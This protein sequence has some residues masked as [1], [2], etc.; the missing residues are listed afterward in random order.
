MSN[1]DTSFVLES[2]QLLCDFYKINPNGLGMVTNKK[3][4]PNSAF[5]MYVKALVTKVTPGVFVDII[6]SI[7]MRVPK[8]GKYYVSVIYTKPDPRGTLLVFKISTI[9]TY[10]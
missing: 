5:E 2:A 7:E 1:V 4:V 10:N 8:T 9:P 6:S 3:Q